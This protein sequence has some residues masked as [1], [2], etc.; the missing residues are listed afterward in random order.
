VILPLDE[1]RLRPLGPAEGA[2][3]AVTEV[4]EQ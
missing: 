1:A 3:E 4:A 2:G